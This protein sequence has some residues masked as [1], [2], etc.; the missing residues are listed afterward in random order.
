M[1][2][3][4]Y[5]HAD[6]AQQKAQYAEDLHVADEHYAVAQIADLFDDQLIRRGLVPVVKAPDQRSKCE[7][8]V[9]ESQQQY[10]NRREKQR[11][12]GQVYFHGNNSEWLNCLTM[13]SLLSYMASGAGPEP[14]SDSSSLLS[15]KTLCG[16]AYKSI[17]SPTCPI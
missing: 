4:K 8:A 7:E 2:G 16:P 10:R 5:K 11:W 12:S 9:R 17:V 3:E 1:P 14:A 15:L 13:T 6:H